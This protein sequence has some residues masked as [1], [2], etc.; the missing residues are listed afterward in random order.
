MKGVMICGSDSV[1]QCGSGAQSMNSRFRRNYI[2]A[3]TALI[4]LCDFGGIFVDSCGLRKLLRRQAHCHRIPERILILILPLPLSET[5]KRTSAKNQLGKIERNIELLDR[6]GCW[7]RSRCTLGKKSKQAN[8]MLFVRQKPVHQGIV[9]HRV[10]TVK[11]CT[12][13]NQV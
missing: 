11:R 12:G 6:R 2:L 4:L 13:M 10:P 1:T 3:N 5:H 7:R 8:E 9:N